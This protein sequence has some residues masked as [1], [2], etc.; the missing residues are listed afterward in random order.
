MT[1][2]AS[3]ADAAEAIDQ[4]LT[5]LEIKLSFTEDTVD[6]LNDVV[7]RQQQQIEALTRELLELRRLVGS[8][9]G[10]GGGDGGGRNEVPPHY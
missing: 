6:R 7:V 1:E 4:R 9:E 3:D 10:L 8:G 5:D 2:A